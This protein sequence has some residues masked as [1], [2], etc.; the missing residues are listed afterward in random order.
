LWASSRKGYWR[1]AGSWVLCYALPNAYW[2]DLGLHGFAEPYR[3][4]RDATRTA[5]CRPARPVVW[6]R[7]GKPGAYPISGYRRARPGPGLSGC[8]G[9]RPATSGVCSMSQFTNRMDTETFQ[10]F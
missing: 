10:V 2:A 5:G 4:F 9:S 1:I 8:S 6:G 3:R 7:R